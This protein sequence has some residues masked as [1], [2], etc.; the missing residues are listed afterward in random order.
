MCGPPASGKSTWVRREAKPGDQ[1]VDFDQICRSLGSRSHHDH[2][3]H[4]RQMAKA[5]R[6]SIEDR[7]GEF[8]GRTFVIR[9]L[10]DPAQ[11]T[12]VAE[13]LGARVVVFAVPL[14]T[15]L[16][17]AHGDN[18]PEWTEDAIQAW[19]ERYEPAPGDETAE[20]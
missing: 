7:A 6:R 2:P 19:W 1:I 18:R 9:S 12:A 8:P 20:E 13:R 15:A 3:Q 10:P 17:R 14:E 5:L 4:V 11:R 16:E